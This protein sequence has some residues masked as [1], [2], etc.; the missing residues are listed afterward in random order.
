MS[1]V[2]SQALAP[3]NI[4]STWHPGSAGSVPRKW[5]HRSFLETPR[6][7]PLGLA[8]Q[9]EFSRGPSPLRSGADGPTRFALQRVESSHVVARS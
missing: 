6:K 9:I 4:Q 7:P 2:H 5:W 3:Y 8:L 1:A